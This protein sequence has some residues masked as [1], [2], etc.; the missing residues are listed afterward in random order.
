MTAWYNEPDPYA[1]QWLRNLIAA[2]HIAP[3]VVDERSIA[4]VRANELA[5]FT[6]CHFFA[7]IGVWSRAL[8]VA[9]WPDDRP[10]WT[11]SCPCQPF[12]IIGQGGGFSDVRHL[13]PDWHRLIHWRKPPVVVGEQSAN[14]CEWLDL[15]AADLENSDY[16]FGAALLRASGFQGAHDRP[17]WYFVALEHSEREGLEGHAWDGNRAAGWTKPPRSAATASF[18][19]GTAVIGGNEL[20]RPIEPGLIPVAPADSTTVGRL[21][22]YGNSLDAET[23]AQFV[24]AVM[25]AL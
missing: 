8:R 3:G 14:A 15:V 7:G 25:E 9:G 22:A 21:R 12:S 6:Q 10:V 18:P 20:R 13:R 4:D 23:A 2:G 16:T 19:H 5:G 17:R 24:G 11:G 1:A